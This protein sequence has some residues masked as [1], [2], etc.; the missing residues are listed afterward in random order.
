M[1]AG[2]AGAVHPSL[3]TLLPVLNWPAGVVMSVRQT[4]FVSEQRAGLCWLKN[5]SQAEYSARSA[6]SSPW[7]QGSCLWPGSVVP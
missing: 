6:S 4:L 1:R 2:A 3:W 7:G 5:K